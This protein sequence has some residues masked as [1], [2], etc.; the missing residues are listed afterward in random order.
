MLE[1]KPSANVLQF[2]PA[3]PCRLSVVTFLRKEAEH[4]SNGKTVGIPAKV[5]EDTEAQIKAQT[6]TMHPGENLH[7]EESFS[8]ISPHVFK[9]M[10]WQMCKGNPQIRLDKIE[11]NKGNP[12]IFSNT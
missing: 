5:I 12:M 6:C 11:N 9:W 2:L 8:C 3:L 10:R 1:G 7:Y 4:K